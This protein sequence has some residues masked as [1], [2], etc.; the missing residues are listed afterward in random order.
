MVRRAYRQTRTSH[1][2]S[3]R[4]S[5]PYKNRALDPATPCLMTRVLE[6]APPILVAL[7]RPRAIERPQQRCHPAGS[8]RSALVL[9]LRWRLRLPPGLVLL[10]LGGIPPDRSGCAPQVFSKDHWC[11]SPDTL[12]ALA[13]RLA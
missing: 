6:P 9:V 8:P 12:Q 5:L 10:V 1:P 7:E 2:Y 11:M 3:N 13:P 4:R